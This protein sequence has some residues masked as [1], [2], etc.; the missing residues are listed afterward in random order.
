MAPEMITKQGHD[1]S[2]DYWC[3]GV[4]AFELLAGRD[5]FSPRHMKD[6]FL[7]QDEIN[8]NI[9][10]LNIQWPKDFPNVMAKDFISKLLKYFPK[11]RLN[12]QQMKEHPWIK[13]ED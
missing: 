5:P 8:R 10:T 3:L 13:M 9:L 12:I 4:L 6:R 1:Y 2:L 11:E 7:A